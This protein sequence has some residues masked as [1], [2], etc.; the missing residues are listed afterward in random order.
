MFERSGNGLNE[1][2]CRHVP[3]RTEENN[4]NYRVKYVEFEVL[5]LPSSVIIAPCSPYKN[6]L[7]GGYVQLNSRR[8]AQDSNRRAP[9]QSPAAYSLWVVLWGLGTFS[10]P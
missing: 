6:R 3:K 4:G 9:E 2:L 8:S 1:V 7:F 5:V 10:F